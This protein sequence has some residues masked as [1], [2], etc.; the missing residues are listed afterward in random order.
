M[1]F[2][3]SPVGAEE[4]ALEAVAA[5]VPRLVVDRHRLTEGVPVVDLLAEGGAA[6]SKGEARRLVAQNGVRLNGDV[7]ADGRSMV[8]DDLLHG[9]FALLRRGKDAYLVVEAPPG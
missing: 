7:V 6:A 5:E 8:E 2:G 1:L 9:R 4:A 3:G